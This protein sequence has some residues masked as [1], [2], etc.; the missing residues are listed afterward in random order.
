MKSI[1]ICLVIIVIALPFLTSSLDG[2]T[3]PDQSTLM[4]H[5]PARFRALFKTTKG[6]F[7]I[8]VNRDWSPLGADRLY[9]LLMTHFYD[10]NGIFRVQKGYVVQFGICDKKEVNAFWDRQII[11]D[12]PVTKQNLQGTLSFARD[13][14]NSRTV[15]LFINLKDNL[16][17]DTVNFNGLR[18]FPPVAKVISGY[19]VIER[20]F[21]EYGFEPAKFQDSVMVQ[22]NEYLRHHWPL[23]DYIREA[24]L[25]EY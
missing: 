10:N 23:I 3:V 21:G 4:A 6:D 17:L 22:G 24:V 15:Q 12:E 11:P 2:Q 5:A 16:K 25:I 1:I 20:L 19:E 13:G 18:G 14:I 9:Q 7:I 8:E